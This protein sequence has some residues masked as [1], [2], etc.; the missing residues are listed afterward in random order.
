MTTYD[1][2]RKAL[3]I[4]RQAVSDDPAAQV[5]LDVVV[6]WTQELESALN[7]GTSCLNCAKVMESSY[8]DLE[9]LE[10]LKMLVVEHKRDLSNAREWNELQKKALLRSNEKYRLAH[11]RAL[12]AEK[13][14]LS[15][16]LIPVYV[17][18]HTFDGPDDGKCMTEIFGTVC[19][20]GED[21]HHMKPSRCPEPET[22]NCDCSCK[23][24]DVLGHTCPKHVV[25]SIADASPKNKMTLPAWE[26]EILGKDGSHYYVS[27]ACVHDLHGECRLTCNFCVKPYGACL[28]V[29][30]T[31]ESEV[32]PE[33]RNIADAS[34]DALAQKFPDHAFYPNLT[35]HGICEVVQE[36][37]SLCG[38]TE[39]L[40]VS[41]PPAVDEASDPVCPA[42]GGDMCAYESRG[43]KRCAS[44]CELR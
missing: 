44:K 42:S 13:K 37:G 34:V 35:F 1:E 11:R 10:K 19:G 6:S 26:A 30:H 33:V 7:W 38:L 32:D 24:A 43:Y 39:D 22:C 25:R 9:Q 41:E 17:T 40:H 8:A 12:E 23:D 31:V 15:M 18:D 14:L 5:E 27:T 3:D 28:C 2:I 29:C 4:L 36:D 16:Q 21:F 20:L